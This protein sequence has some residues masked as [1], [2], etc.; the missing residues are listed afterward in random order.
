MFI[1][2]C[3]NPEFTDTD[4]YFQYI[5]KL[6]YFRL[7]RQQLP[8]LRNITGAAEGEDGCY[9]KEDAGASNITNVPFI[10]NK[11]TLTKRHTGQ[12]PKCLPN[13]WIR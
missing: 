6:V 5:S 12:F 9:L 8:L 4:H 7:H 2:L 10:Y 13:N 1:F 3:P 11:P